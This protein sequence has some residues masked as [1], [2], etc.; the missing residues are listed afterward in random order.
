[1]LADP[2]AVSIVIPAYNEAAVIA[3]VV[4]SLS[5]PRPWREIIVVDDGSKDGTVRARDV[6]RRH[7]RAAPYNKGQRRRGQDAASAPPP[8]ST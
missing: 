2:S 1:M 7:G 6:G 4:A 5:R 8:A 3:D